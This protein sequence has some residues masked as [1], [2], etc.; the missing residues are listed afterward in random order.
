[1]TRPIKSDFR[2]A[3]RYV[4]AHRQSADLAV[5]QIPYIRYTFSY[6][7]SGRN[8]PNDT[9]ILGIDGLY[10]NH[11]MSETEAA[12]RMAHGTAAPRLSG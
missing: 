1:M 3:A 5:Y 6:Y 10:T 2:A 8:D 11:G 7:A 9:A 12:D 4:A